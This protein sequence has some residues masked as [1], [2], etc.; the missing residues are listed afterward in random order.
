MKYYYPY[1]SDRPEMKN[2]IITKDNE[3]VY[4][5]QASASDLQFIKVKK[6][7]SDI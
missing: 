2:Y 1:R 4:F 6:E 7:N 3:K 5:G